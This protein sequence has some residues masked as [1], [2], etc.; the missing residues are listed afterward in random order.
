[1]RRGLLFALLLVTACKKQ[2]PAGDLPPAGDPAA[3][4]A[5]ANPHGDMAPPANPHGDMAASPPSTPPMVANKT[6]PKTPEK[7]ADGRLVLGPFSL[8]PPP[9]WTVKPVTSSMRA[10][11][12]MLPGNDAELIV[13]YFGEGG[14][15]SID[16]NLDRWFNQFK[17]ADG[18]P[19]RDAAKIEKLKFG[20]QDATYVSVSGRF[21]AGAMPGAT[22]AVDKP[23]QRMLAAIVASP[24][25]PYYFKLVGSKATIDANT[26]AFVAM[27]TSLKVR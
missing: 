8:A 26:A 18:K 1:M 27:L 10:A 23:D 3:K 2:P 25:G 13:Y 9:K 24:S 6:E 7:L 11:D 4:P 17:Q 16:D 5:V 20:G 14:A 19:S 12:F 21:V 22:E 15:G